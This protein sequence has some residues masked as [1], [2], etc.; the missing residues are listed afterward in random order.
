MYFATALV[1]L[2][3]RVPV[4]NFTKTVIAAAMTSLFLGASAASA[5]TIWDDGATDFND[6]NQAYR[7]VGTLRFKFESEGGTHNIG[8]QLFGANSVDGKG[9]GYSDQWIVRVNGVRALDGYFNMSG[10]GR[11]DYESELGWVAETITNPGGYFAG[12]VTNVFGLVDLLP[13][14]NWFTVRFSSPGALNN[15]NQGLGDESWALNNVTVSPVPVPAALPLMLTGL[16]G[17]GALKM[18][19]RKLQAA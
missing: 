4:R 12:G 8:F 15:G 7:G 17:F 6:V 2:G 10:G 1:Y 5:A 13:G 9:N 3:W 16:L 14:R 11:N 18:R 19:R